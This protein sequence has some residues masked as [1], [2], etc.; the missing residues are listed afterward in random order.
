M[1]ASAKITTSPLDR[2]NA[3]LRA[4]DRL[5]ARSPDPAVTS[6]NEGYR[7]SQ[8]ALTH[9]KMSSRLAPSAT[10]T[11]LPRWWGSGWN[12]ISTLMEVIRRPR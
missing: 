1:S 2:M 9:E 8:R 5:I 6:S 11:V 10:R 7:A 12:G 3:S 4:A